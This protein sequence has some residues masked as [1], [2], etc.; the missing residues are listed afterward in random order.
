M[1]LF[2]RTVQEEEA[3][4]TII[5]QRHQNRFDVLGDQYGQLIATKEAQA[6]IRAGGCRPAKPDDSYEDDAYRS[7]RRRS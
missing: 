1:Y 4:T 3:V 7:A 5:L 2:Q 6:F